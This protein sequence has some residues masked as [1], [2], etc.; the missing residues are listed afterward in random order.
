MSKP[1]S[2]YLA[3]SVSFTFCEACEDYRVVP[4]KLLKSWTKLT[5]NQKQ[6]FRDIVD[7]VL[8]AL[9]DPEAGIT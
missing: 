6:V 9:G 3:K 4:S 8:K 2:D 5:K 7:S 1:V